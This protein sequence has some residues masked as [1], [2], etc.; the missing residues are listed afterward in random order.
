VFDER[1]ATVTDVRPLAIHGMA[2]VDVALALD[3][4]GAL[5][6][7]LGP[8]AV[9]AGL[10]TGDRVIAVAVMSNVIELRRVEG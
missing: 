7:R 3:A 10:T 9:P 8:E 6:A 2:Y 1:P 5:S 4:G